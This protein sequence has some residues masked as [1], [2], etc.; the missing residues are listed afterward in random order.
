MTLEEAERIL[1][2]ETTIGAINEIK[3]Y[4]GFNEEKAIAEIEKASEI[5]AI[6]IQ[7]KAEREKGCEY[8]NNGK[9]LY[10]ETTDT[11]LYINCSNGARALY[12]ETGFASI[13]INSAYIINYC[14][15]CGR[16][17]EKDGEDNE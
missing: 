1:N 3:Y 17:L 13:P 7:E 16:K 15:N 6:A 10:Q 14:P 12:V 5:G 9:T 2:P 8:C 11:K 4:C